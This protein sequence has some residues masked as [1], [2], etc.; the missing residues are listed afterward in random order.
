MNPNLRLLWKGTKA[1]EVAE[2]KYLDFGKFLGVSI[3]GMEDRVIDLLCCIDH[4][5]SWN[6]KEVAEKKRM[7]IEEQKNLCYKKGEIQRCAGKLNVGNGL[8]GVGF[9]GLQNH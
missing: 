3:E 8:K 6:A 4:E 1:F 9:D 5:V 7:P 2:V